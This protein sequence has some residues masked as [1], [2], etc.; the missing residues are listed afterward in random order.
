MT[1][2]MFINKFP[3]QGKWEGESIFNALCQGFAIDKLPAVCDPSHDIQ[4]DLGHQT[5]FIVPETWTHSHLLVICLAVFL[6]NFALICFCVKRKK[7]THDQQIQ[8]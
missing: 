1:P 5:D 3:Y 8:E 7:A 2:A 4:E 6:L